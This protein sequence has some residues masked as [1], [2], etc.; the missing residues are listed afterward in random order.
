MR[1]SLF[2]IV[3]AA[4]VTSC[5]A[6]PAADEPTSRSSSSI[7]NGAADAADPAVVALVERRSTCPLRGAIPFCSGVLVAPD[8][9][10]TAAHCAALHPAHDVEVFAGADASLGSGAFAAVASLTLHPAYDPATDA[11]DLALLRLA[12]PLSIAPVKI[13]TTLDASIVGASVRVV[14]FGVDRADG[15]AG[16][17]RSGTATVTSLGAQ[18]LRYAPSP[19]NTCSADS[20]GPTFATVA[21]VEELVA[22]TRSGDDACL[23]WG[24]ATR[25]DV[26][27]SFLARG[28][29]AASEP[30]VSDTCNGMCASDDDCPA[31]ML[32]LSDRDGA[33]RCGYLQARQGRFGGACAAS[34]DCGGASCEVFGA[35][36]EAACRCFDATACS[37]EVADAGPAVAVTVGGGGG[38]AL[39]PPRTPCASAF[40]IAL[41][42][43][44]ARRRSLRRRLSLGAYRRERVVEHHDRGPAP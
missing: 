29:A 16:P 5:A 33:R 28:P 9:V 25:V 3:A 19:S 23:V 40:A 11:D 10:L 30:S 35:G 21:G 34:S 22:V 7:T 41:G 42:L 39:S 2:A 44:A 8:V 1:A 12:S 14:G 6:P 27:A 15:V 20:G 38:C 26:F 18:T 37:A 17:K 36:G 4:C 31:S 32:C 13:A 24:D 43:V